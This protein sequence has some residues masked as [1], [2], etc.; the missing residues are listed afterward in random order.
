M[1]RR[2]LVKTGVFAEH[3]NECTALIIVYIKMESR[4]SFSHKT[5]RHQSHK[6]HTHS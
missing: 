2:R 4:F 6:Y 3:L 1:K 5:W